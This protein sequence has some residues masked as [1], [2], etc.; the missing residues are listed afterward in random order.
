MKVDELHHVRY[1]YVDEDHSDNLS[2]H[3]PI[4]CCLTFPV[5]WIKP[6]P[7][8]TKCRVSWKKIQNP[9]VLKMYQ[10]LVSRKLSCFNSY[11]M[12][13]EQDIEYVL[14]GIT[15]ILSS[16]AKEFLPCKRNRPI[17]RPYWNNDLKN[18]RTESR[19]CR[20]KWIA[21]GRPRNSDNPAFREYKAAKCE[22]RKLLRR[23]CFEHERNE[24]SNMDDFMIKIVRASRKKF[25]LNR[26]HIQGYVMN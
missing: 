10:K 13:G 20:R 24:F 17:L 4:C 18:A 15:Q 16:S 5:K 9:F 23:K 21:E 6:L 8:D 7:N 11:T 3:L 12:A 1:C 14:S 2:F 25:Q 22:F 19:E 26:N